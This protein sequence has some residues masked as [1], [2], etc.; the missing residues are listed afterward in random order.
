MKVTPVRCPPLKDRVL[1]T[2]LLLILYG[3]AG[4]QSLPASHEADHAVPISALEKEFFAAIRDGDSK[5]VLSYIPQRGV[6]L[7]S[8]AQP[9]PREEVEQQF[10]AHRGLYCK[11]FDSSCIHAPID[12]ANSAPTCSDRELL[13]HSKSVRTASS[14][15][16][17]NGVQQAVLVARITNDQC[18]RQELIDF[19]FNLEAEGWK[20]FSIP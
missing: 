17:R 9:A 19:I 16:T 6:N 8:Q 1:L 11:L 18:P 12:L 14:E 2:A 7:G 20:L 5:K 4:A 13:T 15:I 10:L 3:L